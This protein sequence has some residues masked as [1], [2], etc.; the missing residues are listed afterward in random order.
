MSHCCQPLP[1]YCCI[2]YGPCIP[3]ALTRSLN[4]LGNA[5]LQD[6]INTLTASQM[7][8][9]FL[10]R[11]NIRINIRRDNTRC[12]TTEGQNQMHHYK[13]TTLVSLQRDNTRC[14]LTGRHHQ[15]ILTVRQYQTH[16]FRGT[17]SVHPFSGT[18]IDE[19][20]QR[21][22]NILR[23]LAERHQHRDN[24]RYVQYI[25]AE[26]HQQT[27]PYRGTTPDSSLQTER[28]QIHSY[29][30]TTS[31]TVL[32]SYHTSYYVPSS[33]VTKGQNTEL[34]LKD[35]YSITVSGWKHCSLCQ[36]D[37]IRYNLV[38]GQH[39]AL[40]FTLLKGLN[41]STF[42][43]RISSETLTVYSGTE[44]PVHSCKMFL[45]KSKTFNWIRIYEFL[46]YIY[47]FADV[48]L[49]SRDC[50]HNQYRTQLRK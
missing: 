12:V 9:I 27:H 41:C 11:D 42:V 49:D 46:M 34:L 32:Q 14:I 3:P 17:I 22:N 38:K 31:Y 36:N 8:D 47:S 33:T 10:R 43:S 16:S 50:R 19:S 45:T 2:Q 7:A 15:Y 29:R 6:L 48:I 23:V 30:G 39:L 1:P 25:L 24:T 18:T 5:A 40:N 21:D 26:G 44:K 28:E 37:N 13:G 20:L 35:R 4:E